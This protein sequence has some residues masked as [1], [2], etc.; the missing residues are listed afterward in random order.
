[1]R[2]SS[3]RCTFAAIADPQSQ[4]VHLN[5]HPRFVS[6]TVRHAVPGCDSISGA[7]TP[8]RNG[9]GTI[10]RSAMRG[11]LGTATNRPEPSMK[12]TLATLSQLRSG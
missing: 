8:S 2:S 7:N 5:G 6:Q 3:N 1:M 4:N 12:L 9:D 11:R 10:E